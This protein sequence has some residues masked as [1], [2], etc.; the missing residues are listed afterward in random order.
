MLRLRRREVGGV[1]EAELAPA[2]TRS[3]W[4]HPAVRGEHTS[5]R[6]SGPTMECPLKVTAVWESVGRVVPLSGFGESR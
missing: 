6:W 2:A 4:F 5:T 1:M 3:G